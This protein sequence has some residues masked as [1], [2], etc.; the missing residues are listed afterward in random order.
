M[1]S[2]EDQYPD[3]QI[4]EGERIMVSPITGTEYRVTRWVEKADG[5]AIALDKEALDDGE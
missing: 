4:K 2:L 1:D 5:R 3:D